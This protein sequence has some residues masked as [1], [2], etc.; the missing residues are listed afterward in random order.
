MTARPA[1]AAVEVAEEPP[2]PAPPRP[3][4]P[5][6]ARSAYPRRAAVSARKK[7][8]EHP[9]RFYVLVGLAIGVGIVLAYWF[10]HYFP[11]RLR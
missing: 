10:Y 9:V 5:A 7:A 3:P 11:Y 6:P 8:P 1:H 2:P 4:T